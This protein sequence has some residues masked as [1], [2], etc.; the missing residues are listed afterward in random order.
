MW[1]ELAGVL[2][3]INAAYEKLFALG[4]KK[5]DFLVTINLK[6]LEPLLNEESE[7]AEKVQELENRRRSVLIRLAGAKEKIRADMTMAELLAFAPT[8]I[9]HT[10]ATL[11]RQLSAR[12]EKVMKQ[13]EINSLLV[14]G[15][16]S[17][18]TTRLNKLGGAQVEPTYGR[19]GGDMI[20]H[21][22]KFDFNA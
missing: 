5:H 11:H 13:N 19:N 9:Q 2:G 18:V 20:S 7:L 10:L 1:Q 3:D 6:G 12:V 15:A 14:R 4:K 21:Q 17:A 22:K 16:L 8:P